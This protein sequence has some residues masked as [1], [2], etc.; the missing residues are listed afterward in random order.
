MYR[1]VFITGFTPTQ[2]NYGGP[3]AMAYHFFKNRPSDSVVRVYTTNGNNVPAN[4]IAQVSK[5]LDIEI[6]VLKDTLYNYFHRREKFEVLRMN[7]GIDKSYNIS[8][9]KLP[10]KVLDEIQTFNPNLVWV[11]QESLTAIINQ[12]SRFNLMVSGFDCFALHCNRV[13]RDPYTYAEPLRYKKALYEYN[14][15]LHRELQLAKIPCKYFDVGIEDRNMFEIVTGR[16]DAKFYPHPHYQVVPKKIDFSKTKL[17][18]LISG[19]YDQYTWTDTNKLIVLLSEHK[20]LASSFKFTFLGKGW[21]E[22][23]TKLKYCG[24]NVEY[25]EWVDVYAEECVQHDI[26]IFPISVGSG[27]KGKV[28][29]ALSMGLLCIGSEIA[30]ENIYVKSGHSCFLYSNMQDV[31]QFLNEIKLN[32]DVA[33][34]IAENGRRQVLKWHNP[35]RI[36]KKILDD[37]IEKI[38]YDAVSE[39]NQVINELS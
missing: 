28:L 33:H 35:G 7:L 34:I 36:F 14:M 8:N 13:M 6:V 11:Y 37:V 23:A 38:P 26:Q 32:R 18:I 10:N 27:T 19:K 30:M 17:S 20:E 29:D 31:L 2:D 25:K 12:L 21:G 22:C 3:S 39:Y 15:V 16:K 24:Y 4:M 5:D 9:Y 1:I